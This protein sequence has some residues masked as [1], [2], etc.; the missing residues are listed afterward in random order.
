MFDRDIADLSTFP[1]EV[2]P[3]V[4]MLRAAVVRGILGQGFGSFIVNVKG[5]G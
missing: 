3:G 2:V 5:N 4:D 1:H